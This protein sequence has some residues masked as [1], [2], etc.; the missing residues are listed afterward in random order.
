MEALTLEIRYLR[1][2]TLECMRAV[3]DAGFEPLPQ[4]HELLLD[5][6]LSPV[7]P[8]YPGVHQL[9]MYRVLRDGV[10]LARRLLRR[11][12]AYPPFMQLGLDMLSRLGA[13]SDVAQVYVAAKEPL[14]AARVIVAR[15]IAT[16]DRVVAAVVALATQMDAESMEWERH[17]RK[18]FLLKL[19]RQRKETEDAENAAHQRP[20]QVATVPP[21]GTTEMTPVA[22]IDCGP[23]TEE[24]FLALD[25]TLRQ[26]SLIAPLVT[27]MLGQVKTRS[28]PSA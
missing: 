2:V 16:D 21:A 19:A 7:A 4:M 9:V 12:D 13:W 3:H 11:A 18:A 1:A 28:R 23:V 5:L 27:Q 6:C 8:D 15:N 26:R 24:A 14:R 20:S 10:A 22:G 17:G 25:R